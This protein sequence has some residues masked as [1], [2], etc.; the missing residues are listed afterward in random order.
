[1]KT[2]L[3]WLQLTHEKLRLLVA[4]AGV[5]F[6]DILIFTQLGFQGALF[7]TNVRLHESLLGDAF[8]LSPQTDSFNFSERFSQRRLYQALSLKEVASVSSLYL[9]FAAWK[10]PV[11][12][13]TR[14][15]M[16]VGIDPSDRTLGFSELGAIQGIIQR[17]DVVLYDRL[18]K[19]EF[20]PVAERFE[21]GESVRTELGG[22]RVT[23]GGLYSQGIS[24]FA[25][26]NVITS[27]VNFL[28]L[29]PERSRSE[30]D[31]GIIRLEPGADLEAVLG[32]LRDVL[33][34]DVR[35]FSKAE[36]VEYEKNYWR[37][38]T[39]IGFVFALGTGLGFVV[40]TVFVYQILYTEVNDRLPGYATL[41]AMGY[42]DRFFIW[43]VFQQALILAALGYIPGLGLTLVQYHFI[44][45][46]SG[47]PLAM[48]LER[49]GFVL[50]LTAGMCS[51]SGAIAVRRLRAADPADIF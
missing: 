50:V 13:S 49:A 17:Q 2:P 19:A 41:K 9:G 51:V 3:S 20:G 45:Q 31:L 18:S 16:V 28:R 30:I 38:S 36:L 32:T 5:A 33:P 40:G 4:I 37:T 14:S 11:D 21:G 1:M 12:R 15:M 27:D 39:T 44:A 46:S 10:N 42:R 24:F 43:V 22:R 6:A 29:F 23:V 47:L 35:V 25:D 34:E 26:G 7:G 8:L 48:T